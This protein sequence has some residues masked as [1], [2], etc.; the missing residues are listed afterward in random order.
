MTQPHIGLVGEDG[1]EAIIPLG[2]KRKSRGISLWAEAGKRLGILP[3]A[4]GGLFGGAP[5]PQEAPEPV[6]GGSGGGG[7]TNNV[8]I[9]VNV[10]MAPSFKIEGDGAGNEQNIMDTIERHMGEISESA[11]WEIAQRLR[12]IF[13][14]M[15]MTEVG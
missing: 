11:A 12:Q 4:E 1:P 15:P 10:S 13:P 8:S 2:A 9:S 6:P 5:A 14:N 7:G 3:H